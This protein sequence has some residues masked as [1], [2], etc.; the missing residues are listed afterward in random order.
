MSRPVFVK[1]GGSILTDKNAPEALA[2]AT[3]HEVAR[4]LAA[5]RR[6]QPDLAL[7]LGHGGG[8]FG[9]YWADKYRTAEGIRGPES[10]WGVARVADAMARL[11]R[12][13]VAALLEA[14]I[15]A[16]GVQ[17][18]ASAQA[19]GGRITAIGH[20]QLAALLAGE[21][22]PVIYGDVL[23]DAAQGC[24][25]ASTETIFA[26]LAPHLQPRRIVLVGEEAVYDDDP[27]RNP[28]ARP[29]ARIDAAN[30]AAVLARLGGSHGVDVT[31]GMRAKVEAMWSLASAAPELE[32]A[33]CGPAALAAALRGDE[34]ANGTI[35]RGATAPL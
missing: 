26:A 16:L 2:T 35:I 20:R 29:I 15:P 32:I 34:L 14:E 5:I 8:S 24:T 27:R 13:V 21:I 33:I 10:W 28:A 22:V 19:S 9:H 12:A 18:L 11:N 31:G 1:L 7:L 3:L 23:L 30:Y 25:I 4:T 17:P 6:E